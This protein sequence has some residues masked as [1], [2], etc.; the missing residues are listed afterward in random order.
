MRDTVAHRALGFAV[1]KR[2]IRHQ[3]ALDAILVNALLPRKLHETINCK[4]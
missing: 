3:D 2:L 4:T 1:G